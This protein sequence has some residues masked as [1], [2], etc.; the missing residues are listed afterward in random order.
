MMSR[1]RLLAAGFVLTPLATMLS[2]CGSNKEHWEAGMKTIRWDRDV[3]PSCRMVISD[4]RFAAE[5]CGATNNAAF[6]FDDI[7]C[8]MIWLRDKAQDY[9]WSA[10]PATRIWVAD[11]ASKRD[12]LIWLDAHAAHYVRRTSPMGYNF[13]ANA[14]AQTGAV[15]FQ[16]MREQ[17]LASQCTM[18]PVQ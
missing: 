7:G 1:R 12:N 3:C 2:A 10:D 18:P 13:G 16:T 15:D 11:L 6:A 5:I 14:Q 4:R 17:V 8:A 9:P